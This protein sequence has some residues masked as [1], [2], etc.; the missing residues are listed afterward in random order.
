MNGQSK[1]FNHLNT[2]AT[3]RFESL[4]SGHLTPDALSVI[5]TILSR[6]IGELSIA[7]HTLSTN[8]LSG[9]EK[10]I[11]TFDEQ[12]VQYALEVLK[13]AGLVKRDLYAF[14]DKTRDRLR[15]LMGRVSA[16]IDEEYN[17]QGAMISS[18]SNWSQVPDSLSAAEIEAVLAMKVCGQN[19]GKEGSTKSPSVLMLQRLATPDKVGKKVVLFPDAVKSMSRLVRSCQSFVFDICSAVPMKNLEGMSGLPIWK[20]EESM[21]STNTPDTYGTL[22]QTH[23]TQVGEHML[24]LVQALE[25]F[26]SDKGVLQLA[27]LVMDGVDH[28]CLKY[29]NSFID[30]IDCQEFGGEDL[31][32]EIMIGKTLKDVALRPE[33]MQ[34]LDDEEDDEELQNGDYNEDSAMN[35]FCNKWLDA[36]CTAVTGQLL[37]RILHINLLSKKGCEHLKVDLNY[38]VN[39]FHALGVSGHPHP[40]L[41]HLVVVSNMEADNVRSRLKSFTSGDEQGAAIL[42]V[43]SQSEKKLAEMRGI[44]L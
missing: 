10:L 43:I 11:D 5:D 17:I 21:W 18:T 3:G 25:P 32:K 12:Q 1:L 26:A 6:H 31:V 30:A 41:N 39:V 8:I 20:Q 16:A 15:I 37:D 13:I 14:E 28:V 24:A 34:H 40:L 33:S 19:I 27:N 2:G 35:T 44:S 23:I 29:W 22:P 36:V 38:I 9:G 7:I 4:T 42:K